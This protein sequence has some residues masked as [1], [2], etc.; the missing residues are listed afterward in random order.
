M[1]QSKYV[2]DLLFVSTGNGFCGKLPGFTLKWNVN[3]SIKYVIFLIHCHFITL[4][5]KKI[6]V[7]WKTQITSCNQSSKLQ[8]MSSE[9]LIGSVEMTNN[10]LRKR[11]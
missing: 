4:L 6:L 2:E 8:S 7:S 1:V 10:Q 3:F 11:S 9:P 5:L